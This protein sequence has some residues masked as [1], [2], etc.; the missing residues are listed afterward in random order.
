MPVIASI[1]MVSCFKLIPIKIMKEL[2]KMNKF[3]LLVLLFTWL[4]CIFFDGAIG[5]L[6]GGAFSLVYLKFT[7]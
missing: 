5:L 6:T 7:N 4:I 2:F 1:L 3:D